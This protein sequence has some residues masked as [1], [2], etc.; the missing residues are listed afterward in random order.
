MLL[1]V[2]LVC[3]GFTLGLTYAPSFASL[4]SEDF[5]PLPTGFHVCS[6][7]GRLASALL[8]RA[9]SPL[10]LFYQQPLS[11]ATTTSGPR[12]TNQRRWPCLGYL[13]RNSYSGMHGLLGGAEYSFWGLRTN[14]LDWGDAQIR[15]TVTGVIGHHADILLGL[16]LIPVSRNSVLGRAFELHRS[17]LLYAH[18]FIAYLLFIVV[19]THDTATYVS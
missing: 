10:C 12:Q 2:L 18:K 6:F 3:A 1:I 11:H 9:Y 5:F 7:Y 15:L 4:C 16:A 13:A 8:L 14:P 17:T 19:L